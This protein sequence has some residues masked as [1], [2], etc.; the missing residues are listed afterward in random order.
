MI[1]VTGGAGFIGSAFIWELNQLGIDD[2][3]VVDELGEDEKWKNLVSLKFSDYLEKNYFLDNLF[4]GCYKDQIKSIYHF[5]ACSSTQERNATYLIENNF[6]YTKLLAQ[7]CNQN[8]VDFIYA[9]SAATY[10]DGNR[11]YDD[12]EIENLKPLNMYGYSKQLFDIYAKKHGFFDLKN[13]CIGIKFFNVYGPNEHHKGEMRSMVNK[14]YF[15]INQ[16][17]QINLFK[18]YKKEYED[19]EQKRDFIYIKD[20]IKIVYKL[21]TQ[22]VESGIYNIG[23]GKANSWNEL[24][25]AVFKAMDK[26]D[27]IN[28]IE[29]PEILQGK[30]QYF[31][32]ANMDKTLKAIGDYK[33]FTL[34]EAVKDYVQNYLMQDK[35]LGE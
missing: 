2:I 19:G 3:L 30:Y 22:N 27:N 7:Y 15:Q 33:F 14:S 5:G 4:S 11:G 10:G 16:D 12:T 18:S 17:S 26:K 6:E 20:A 1:V 23:T 28:Y 29:M 8:E 21:G 34:E 24:A 32:E 13:K 31:T 35:Y 25:R 9:S